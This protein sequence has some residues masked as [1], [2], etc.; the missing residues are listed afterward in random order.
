MLDMIG[1]RLRQPL[2]VELAIHLSLFQSM[3]FITEF[4][5]ELP[6]HL[7]D[8]TRLQLVCI[9][10]RGSSLRRI[11]LQKGIDDALCRV[12][13]K[14]GIKNL[15]KRVIVLRNF[16]GL[17]FQCILR[18]LHCIDGF[19]VVRMLLHEVFVLLLPLGF[20]SRHF[21]PP[22]INFAIQLRNIS[23][24]LFDG[25]CGFFN[26]RLKRFNGPLLLAHCFTLFVARIFAPLNKSAEAD[27][28]FV[29]VFFTL[30]KHGRQ[31]LRDLLQRS[32]P[33]RIHHHARRKA[34][35]EPHG[36]KFPV[37]SLQA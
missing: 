10:L 7:Q 13:N 1:K 5:L 31:H 27:T 17:T 3:P 29:H 37:E 11:A 26:A 25:S 8:A 19:I 33:N 14:R 23:I 18:L 22:S 9:R 16:C 15:N 28:L 34:C 35:N 2:V 24:Q 21:A 6:Q 36:F 30:R 12:R 20:Q 4:E 32:N